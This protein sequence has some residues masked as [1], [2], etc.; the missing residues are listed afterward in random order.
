MK[1]KK[2]FS[3]RKERGCHDMKKAIFMIE[4]SGDYGGNIVFR[5][6]KVQLA[7]NFFHPQIFAFQRGVMCRSGLVGNRFLQRMTVHPAKDDEEFH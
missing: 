4:I 6:E 3:R 7:V 1:R 2:L 5:I